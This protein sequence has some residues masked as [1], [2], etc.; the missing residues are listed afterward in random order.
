VAALEVGERAR[1]VGA[2]RGVLRDPERQQR[3]PLGQLGVADLGRARA[4]L[5][6]RRRRRLEPLGAAQRVGE[7]EPEP[8]LRRRRSTVDLDQRANR[9]AARSPSRR[10]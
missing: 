7:E 9:S 8:D 1:G 4:R 5:L 3:Q 2:L 10:P 6:Q